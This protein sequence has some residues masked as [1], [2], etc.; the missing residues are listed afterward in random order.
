MDFKRHSDA[1]IPCRR[2][3]YQ[4]IWSLS[5]NIT[6][7]F[8]AESE[9]HLILSSES[10]SLTVLGSPSV[11]LSNYS[12][13]LI[14]STTLTLRCKAAVPDTGHPDWPNGVNFTWFK[15]G[16]ELMSDEGRFSMI[17][18]MEKI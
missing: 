6:C 1:H 13:T 5:D 16:Q 8:K 15:M 10:V 9:G 7:T 3:F 14:K 12:I 18:E 4:N 11:S 2:F 17:Y